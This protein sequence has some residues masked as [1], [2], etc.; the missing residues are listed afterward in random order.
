MAGSRSHRQVGNRVFV[1]YCLAATLALR[2][3]HNRG[4][5]RNSMVSTPHLAGDGGYTTDGPRL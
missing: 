5:T 4:S 3:R 2:D 1:R